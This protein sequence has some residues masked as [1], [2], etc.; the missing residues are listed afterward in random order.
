MDAPRNQR[1][2]TSYK[3]IK[4]DWGVRLRRE[5]KELAK[6]LVPDVRD[7]ISGT[8][9]E[10]VFPPLAGLPWSIWI[11]SIVCWIRIIGDLSQ[12]GGHQEQQKRQAGL[13]LRGEI[14]RVGFGGHQG[15]LCRTVRVPATGQVRSGLLLGLFVGS[16]IAES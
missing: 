1:T 9:T 7:R 16:T 15:D 5:N 13:A 6:L 10:A 11:G 8:T 2:G 12:G 3:K 4:E 14:K